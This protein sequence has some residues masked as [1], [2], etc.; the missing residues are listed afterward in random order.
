ML[1]A[2]LA[3]ALLIT[4]GGENLRAEWVASVPIAKVLSRR[5]GKPIVAIVAYDV[6][7]TGRLTSLLDTSDNRR[8]LAGFV[9][10]Q[11]LG[12]E[13]TRRLLPGQD[14]PAFAQLVFLSSKGRVLK[15]LSGFLRNDDL[16]HAL[17]WVRLSLDGTSLPSTPSGQLKSAVL[18]A[19]RGDVES[20]RRTL[21]KVGNQLPELRAEVYG[22]IM[23]EMR[24]DGRLRE[25]IRASDEAVRLSTNPE[26][27]LR[28]RIRRAINYARFGD[29]RY[30]ATELFACAQAP[31][32]SIED[33]SQLRESAIRF[34]DP[35]FGSGGP[36]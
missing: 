32:L 21:Q 6:T 4:H 18:V 3:S 23:D 35:L 9:H 7:R 16:R 27:K 15:R 25:A 2:S 31:G 36:R 13:E 20:A 30:A 26:Q 5:S 10:V 17:G 24:A 33:S 14:A 1:L 22:A 29:R 8:M 19:M 34:A 28:W 12:N 11:V